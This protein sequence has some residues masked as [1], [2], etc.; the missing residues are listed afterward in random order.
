MGKAAESGKALAELLL[1]EVCFGVKGGSRVIHLFMDVPSLSI[2]VQL[3]AHS[4]TPSH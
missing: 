3:S 1:F 2:S 4:K